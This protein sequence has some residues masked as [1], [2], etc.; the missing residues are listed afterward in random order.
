[1]ITRKNHT[2]RVPGNVGS[3]SS[4]VSACSGSTTRNPKIKHRKKG[5]NKFRNLILESRGPSIEYY[6]PKPPCIVQA[7]HLPGRVR[8]LG[9]T[10]GSHNETLPD[11]S[12]SYASLCASLVLSRPRHPGTTQ[13]CVLKLSWDVGKLMFVNSTWTRPR[14]HNDFHYEQIPPHAVLRNEYSV[15]F[16]HSAR[17]L[18]RGWYCSTV[19][20]SSSK[21]PSRTI[22]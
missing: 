14:C 5:K 6:I 3:S 1:M 8:N 12:R 21:T 19:G 7:T 2:Q 17:W 9:L 4:L 10:V 22:T 16:I 11:A 15:F 13:P 18:F 20:L